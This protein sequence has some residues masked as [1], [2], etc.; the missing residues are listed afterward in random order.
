MKG[1]RERGRLSEAGKALPLNERVVATV[2]KETQPMWL[3]FMRGYLDR[4][5]VPKDNFASAIDPETKELT[6]DLLQRGLTLDGYAT[7][8]TRWRRNCVRAKSRG[9]WGRPR[10]PSS[11]GSRAGR[12]RLGGLVIAGVSRLTR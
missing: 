9:G 8:A 12:Y 5:G 6:R 11:G 3:Y 7:L 1:D 10:G 2:F 4:V